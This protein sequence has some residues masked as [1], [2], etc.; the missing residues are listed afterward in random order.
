MADQRILVVDDN[1][2]FQTYLKGILQSEDFSISFSSTAGEARATCEK[3]GFDL[4]L[5]DLSLPDADGLETIAELRRSVR[6]REVP[7]V[8]L[9]SNSSLSKKIAA[10]AL[11]ADDYIVKGVDP[12][13]FRSKVEAKLR[14]LKA[15]GSKSMSLRRGPIRFDL[16]AHRAFMTGASGETELGLTS[17]E[18]R[19]LHFLAK[20]AGRA[21]TREQI[22][23]AVWGDNIHVFDRAVDTHVYSVRKKLGDH[24]W[25]IGSVQNVGYRFVEEGDQ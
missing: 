2:E 19:L 6:N 21:F 1:A 16:A 17:L 13:E 23:S 14:N 3:T 8:F 22:L 10:F 4:I 20:N 12:V 24:F 15:M 11:G 18:F 5:L 25:L 9:S 7:V